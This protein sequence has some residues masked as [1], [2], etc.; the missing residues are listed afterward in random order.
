MPRIWRGADIA[1][2]GMPFDQAVTNRPGTARAARDPRGQH[3]AGVRSALWLG[4][5]QPA[6]EFDHRRSRRPGL[7]LCHIPEFPGKLTAH[8]G[9]IL[10]AGAACIALGGDH[11]IT[12]PIL[13]AHAERFGP[14]S[15]LQFDAHSD[16]WV[17]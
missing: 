13:R 7:R 14:L 6:G 12:L 8:V 4:R 2:T 15:L 3:A 17:G 11:Y 5:V 10:D 1:V 9:G 16:T